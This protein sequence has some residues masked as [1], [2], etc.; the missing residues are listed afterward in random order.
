[1]ITANI[2]RIIKKSCPTENASIFSE[3][4]RNGLENLIE[5]VIKSQIPKVHPQSVA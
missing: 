2:S 1:M 4:V 5:K 3:W